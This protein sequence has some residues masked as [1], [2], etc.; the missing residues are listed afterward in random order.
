MSL[1]VM[2][3]VAYI[4]QVKQRGTGFPYENHLVSLFTQYNIGFLLYFIQNNNLQSF[5]SDNITRQ[6]CDF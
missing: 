5:A 4:F 3:T 2:V 1:S 6:I